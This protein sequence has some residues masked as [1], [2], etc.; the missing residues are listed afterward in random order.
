[1]GLVHGQVI[2]QA[3][4]GRNVGRVVVD[5]ARKDLWDDREEKQRDQSKEKEIAN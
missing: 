3:A 5:V 2:S 1:M 4:D